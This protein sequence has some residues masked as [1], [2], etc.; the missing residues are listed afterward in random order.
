MTI[1]KFKVNDSGKI[2]SVCYDSSIKIRDFILDFTGKNTN[3]STIDPNVYTF[4]AG[5]KILNSPRFLDAQLGNIIIENMTV[6]FVRKLNISYSGGYWF[7]KIINIKF[8]KLS[9]DYIYKNDNPEI[10]GLLKLCLLKEVSQKISED[11]LKKLPELIYYIMIFLSKGYIDGDIKESIKKVLLENEGS[12]IINFSNYVDEIIDNNQMNQIFNLLSNDNLK[13]MNDIRYRLSR[14]NKYIKLFNREFEKAKK[15]SY[16]EF[17]VI[18]LVV[19][20]REDFEKFE[21]EREKCPNRVERILFHGTGIEPIASI[22]TGLYRKSLEARKSINGKG[23]YFTDSLDYS[24]YYGGEVDNRANCRGIPKV[25]DTFTMIVNSV[26][27]DKNG[28]AQVKDNTRTPGKN[29]INFAYAGAR[30]ERL[31]QPD[32]NEFFATEY[33]VYDLDQICPFMSV[34][35][36]RDT[37]CVIWRD[38]NFSSKP[39]YNNKFDE[40]FKSF[41][42]ER[43]NYINQT[44]KYN[45]YPC[46]TTEEALELVNRKKYNKIILISNVGTDLGGKKF[47]DKAREIIGE[48]VIALF[49]AY[50]IDHLKWIT[51]YKNAL[52]SNEPKFYEEYLQCFDENDVKYNIRALIEKLENHYQVKFNF[53]E[54]YLNYPHFKNE[55]KYMDL[56]F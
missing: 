16:F 39:V 34:K 28:F 53:D 3:L 35:L 13:E 50:R 15:E 14:Y 11:L 27:Y 44:A 19:I 30:T 18:S 2:I 29:Q 52:F 38:N 45:I 55:G 33:V 22:L 6:N 41:L 48:N 10:F 32:K 37:F 21:E 26:Y 8:I 12:N 40:V 9:K 5:G 1:I 46:E 42:K 23:V 4:K 20:E 43:V 24:W 25:Y 47:V 54:N 51:K 49:L 56:K 36:K 17:S 31:I 7:N